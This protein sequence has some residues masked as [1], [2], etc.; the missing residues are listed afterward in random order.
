[1][2]EYCLQV[3]PGSIVAAMQNQLFHQSTTTCC[4]RD[5]WHCYSELNVSYE[6]YIHSLLYAGRRA[7]CGSGYIPPLLGLK[8][9]AVLNP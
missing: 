9:L 5:V 3:Y 4:Q 8:A 7:E 2:L 6:P 1:M